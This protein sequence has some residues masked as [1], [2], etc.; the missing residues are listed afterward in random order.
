MSYLLDTNAVSEPM[1]LAPESSVLHW[2]EEHEDD[3]FVS[4][5]TIGEIERGIAL[6]PA[7]RKKSRLHE[8][9]RVFSEAIEGRILSFD[10][11][12]ARRWAVLT[13]AAQR[14]GKTLSLPD[15]MIEATALHWDLKLVTRNT[16][17]FV[18]VPTLNP[19]E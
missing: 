18:E 16:S 12:V 8:V 11:A 19:W 4:A 7:G 14:K 15:S 6:L 3:C 17:D 13:S 10:V 2:I 1:K 9:Y 5:I